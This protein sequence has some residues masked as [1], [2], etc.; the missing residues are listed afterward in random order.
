MYQVRVIQGLIVL[1]FV[2]ALVMMAL[3][4]FE[5]FRFAHDTED[6]RRYIS[7]AEWFA[8]S[9]ILLFLLPFF[10]A[11][12]VV[13]RLPDLLAKTGP[14]TP[15]R[16]FD[17]GVTPP[18]GT[19]IPPAA[20]QQTRPTRHVAQELRPPTPRADDAIAQAEAEAFKRAAGGDPS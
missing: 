1:G 15:D 20:P 11:V 7:I 10:E 14:S 6:V 2:L 13:L 19:R 9:V 17:H 5:R 12:L 16:S 3:G 18:R 8:V 4:A